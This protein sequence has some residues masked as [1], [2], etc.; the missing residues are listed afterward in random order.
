MGK[1]KLLLDYNG[2]TLL[3]HSM[4]LLSSLPVFERIC[5]SAEERLCS[6]KGY[7][8]IK[9]YINPKPESGLSGSVHIG[10]KNAAGTHLL[11][12][13]ADQPKLT[14]NDVLALIEAA[15]QNPDK[16]IFP[17]IGKKPTSPTIFPVSF[18]EELLS[19]KGD[20]GGRSIRDA[21]KELCLP[22]TPVNPAHFTDIDNE[23]DYRQAICYE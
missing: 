23:A 2:K 15:K 5:V 4:D 3:D 14:E 17:Q 1:D 9:Y 11:F 7:E 13:S 21:N 6:I 18:R 20:N 16:I 19:Q 8:N 12:L 22:V 10:T